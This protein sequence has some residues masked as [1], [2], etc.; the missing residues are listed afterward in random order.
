MNLHMT[1]HHLEITPSMRDYVSSKMTRINRHFDHV[2]DV[3]MILTVEKLR[4]RIEA[5]VH[6]SGKDI[7]VESADTDMYAAI[8]LLVD[9]LDRQIVKHKE[10]IKRKHLSEAPKRIMLPAEE[11]PHAAL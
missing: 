1:G 11:P 7:F 3:N 4:Q 9:K 8:D 5:N 10:K 2:I 6:L